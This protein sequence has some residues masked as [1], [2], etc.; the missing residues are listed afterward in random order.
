[1]RPSRVFSCLFLIG[2]WL[3]SSPVLAA[4]SFCNHTQNAIE[5]AFGYRENTGWI[6][7]G[8]WRIEPAT[9]ARVF[10]D[11]LTQRFYFYY[12]TSLAPKVK[13]KQP[14]TWT[15]KYKLCVDTKAFR[16]EGDEECEQRDY[17]IRNFQEVDIGTMTHDYTLD[18]KDTGDNR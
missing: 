2:F 12:A 17:Q 1:M 6:S 13:N 7:E 14:L 16:I 18:F 11:S 3:M 8:W 9:C 5:A 10:G 4:M 15:G